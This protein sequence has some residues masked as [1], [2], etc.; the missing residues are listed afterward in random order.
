VTESAG[1]VKLDLELNESGFQRQLNGVANK[2]NG[3]ASAFSNLAMAAGVAF[4]AYEM[5]N[6]GR[7]ATKLA[8]DLQEVQNVVD[9]TFGSMAGQVNS[10]ATTAID[11]FG[12]SELSA[13][14][15]SST[16]G[17]MLKSSGLTGQ[18]MTDM[19]LGVTKLAAD[20]S[21]F[22]NLDQ[23]DAFYKIQ[24]GLSGE[25]EP[26]RRLGVNMTQVNLEAYA[27]SKGITKSFQKMT[28]Q[29]QTLLR[30]NYLL[31]ATKDAQGDFARTSDSWANSTRV[32]TERWNQ[33]K[34]TMGQGFIN[35]FANV[36]GGLGAIIAKL[37]IASLY[38]KA[39]TELVFG[40]QSKVAETAVSAQDASASIGDMGKAVK[41]A[42]KQA[43]KTLA[44]FD[45]L[46]MLTSNISEGSSDV[47][48][49]LTNVGGGS[50]GGDT[51]TTP[52]I[53]TAKLDEINAKVKLFVD[54]VRQQFADLSSIVTLH[55]N[56][57]IAS[58]AGIAA[59]FTT[60]LVISKWSAIVQGVT[61]AFEGLGVAI[62]AISWPV[63]AVAA[64]VG[65]FVAAIVNLWKTNEGF[66]DSLTTVWNNITSFLSN[67]WNNIL[68]P[69]LAEVVTTF[70]WLW[71]THLK[72]TVTAFV[73][74]VNSLI[75][76]AAD[77]LNKFVFPVLN[78]IVNAFGP[79]IVNTF[80]LIINVIGSVIGIVADV[81]SSIF[82]ILGGIIDFLVGVFT[83]NWNKAWGGIMG[84][85]TGIVEIVARPIM[86]IINVV[87][88]M[89][90]YM[91]RSLNN[92]RIDIPD[93]VPEY[94]GQSLGFNV[95]Q[96]PKLA[97]GGLVHQPT[98]AMVGDNRNARTDPE[99]VSPLSN[100]K[101]IMV[102]ALASMPG[103][104]NGNN[105]SANAQEIVLQVGETEFARLIISSVH[106]LQRQTGVTLLT[107]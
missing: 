12:L 85:F 34:A 49:A 87:I 50:I 64:L 91:I 22:Y 4:S 20:L 59:A 9:V 40:S 88:D 79:N 33:F 19:S 36:L 76:G 3:M 106:N 61:I 101:A 89:I 45:Q 10:F 35:I 55:S 8:S 18:G 47:S 73:G 46:N 102:E 51:V 96:I 107:V 103:F 42:G 52:T 83:G 56:G 48:D 97:Q 13:K 17:A 54:S 57:I 72:A 70:R 16:I 71:E 14:R 62:G 82:K 104:N 6:F 38:F 21:S 98:L 11:Q 78:A 68:S 15:F 66:R 75:T 81:A 94:G 39:F 24:A 41:E 25:I 63:V 1:S 65:L 77:I 27:M 80:K 58:I 67:V 2:A 31:N 7:G 74:F 44:P 43:K 26:L 53:N 99:V 93:W 90:N 28:Q 69:I 37:Q 30:Y 60:F 100:L 32:L 5:I 84:V 86:G 105:S 92:I 23:A 29:E 95:K